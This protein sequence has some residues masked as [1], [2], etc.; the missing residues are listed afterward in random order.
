MSAA[1]GSGGAP[2]EVLAGRYSLQRAAWTGARGQVWKARD[3]TLDRPVYVLLLDQA[4]AEDKAARRDF[5]DE[6]G[7]LA[8]QTHPSVAAIYDIGV[9]PVF[10][11]FEDPGGGR[12]SDRLRHGPLDETATA[13][14]VSNLARAM[15]AM[16]DEIH[17][18]DPERILLAPDGRAKIAPLG[19]RSTA[20]VAVR[21]SALAALAVRMLTGNEPGP[22]LSKRDVP[23]EL[24]PVLS[25]ML[26]NDPSVSLEDL[27]TACAALTRPEAI[28]ARSRAAVR[29]GGRG[30]GSG[31]DFGWLIGVTLIVALAVVA[32][33][34]GPRLIETL[35]SS[36]SASP[37]VSKS[38]SGPGTPLEVASITDFDPDGNGEEHPDQVGRVLDDDP[39]TAWST[40]GY[41]R[42]GMDKAGVGLLLDLGSEQPVRTVV[43]QTSLPGWKAEI[44]VSSAETPGASADDFAVAASFVAGTEE[45][46]A[47]PAGTSA[48]F[49]LVWLIELADDEGES[50]F[51]YRASIAELDVFG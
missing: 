17:D 29:R 21:P 19:V 23:Q 37:T 25:A 34:L 46:V 2:G 32:V 36:P 11:V 28:T 50:P 45:R 5:V 39:L 31:S 16:P 49:V 22:K 24:H 4:L 14:I 13:R 35:D 9:D 6:A 27:V 38:P 8:V 42:A 15:Q 44:R 26:Q 7:R 1:A 33:V 30:A 3:R 51:P 18:L 48:R 20:D 12:L 10:A 43:V 47:L 41:K 40:L